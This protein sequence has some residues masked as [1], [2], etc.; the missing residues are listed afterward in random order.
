MKKVKDVFMHDVYTLPCRYEKDLGAI[1]YS[2]D[3]KIFPPALD[4]ITIKSVKVYEKDEENALINL[5]LKSCPEDH[6]IKTKNITW[7]I[8][9][10]RNK[11][12]FHVLTCPN[13][14]SHPCNKEIL[15]KSLYLDDIVFTEA[16]DE[17]TIILTCP[18]LF[19][20]V[21]TSENDQVHEDKNGP[22]RF[23]GAAVLNDVRMSIVCIL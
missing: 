10:A 2:L 15:L 14:I 18:A 21:I 5:L 9:L 4:E 17:N 22:Y 23:F 7:G 1:G 11:V 20:G 19:F 16:I 6:K 13:A 8:D 12:E 3:G